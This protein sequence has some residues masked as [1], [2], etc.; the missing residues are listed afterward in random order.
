MHEDSYLQA[1]RFSMETKRGLARYC[2][3]YNEKRCHKCFDRK[4]PAMLTSV[5]D[6]RDT[7]QRE[8]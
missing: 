4:I 5:P 3:F 1:Y 6:A 2:K 7:Q 8:L